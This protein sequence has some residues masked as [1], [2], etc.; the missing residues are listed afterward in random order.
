M[1]TSVISSQATNIINVLRDVVGADW[2]THSEEIRE[3]GNA[4]LLEWI[5]RGAVPHAQRP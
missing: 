4:L 2:G 3:R 5:P 1:L